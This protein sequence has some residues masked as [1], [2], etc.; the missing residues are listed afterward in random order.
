MTEVIR[1]AIRDS[2]LPLLRIAGEAK[3]ERASL[4]RFMAGKR[5]L[6]LNVADRLAEYFGLE[7]KEAKK[8]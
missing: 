1:Q 6:R 7:L 5:S 4:S 3:V 8:R 2:G